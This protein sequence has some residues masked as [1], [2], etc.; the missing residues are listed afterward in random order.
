[1]EN[2]NA[3]LE[4]VTSVSKAIELYP[5]IH[6]EEAWDR[7][8]F[9]AG[10]RITFH[11]PKQNQ[12]KISRSISV[13]DKTWFSLFDDAEK[14]ILEDEYVFY[15]V[16]YRTTVKMAKKRVDRLVENLE[17]KMT[18]K[19]FRKEARRHNFYHRDELRQVFAALGQL[20]SDD[21]IVLNFI[22]SEWPNVE[23]ARRKDYV[24]EFESKLLNWGSVSLTD[25][26]PF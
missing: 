3:Q 12:A 4:I 20:N 24:K 5:F 11:E 9:M 17:E 22:F 23:K 1:M 7:N 19:S 6:G 10:M 2:T 18:D 13:P 16:E 8:R 14:Q 25:D 21:E 15:G 26:I